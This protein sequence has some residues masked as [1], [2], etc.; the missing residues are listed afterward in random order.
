MKR[1]LLLIAISIIALVSC[2][3]IDKLSEEE[4]N[5]PMFTPELIL[6]INSSNSH[7]KAGLNSKFA[8]ALKRDVKSL[9]GRLE[10]DE[11]WNL[12]PLKHHSNLGDLPESYDA[13]VAH[14]EC[15]DVIGHVQDQSSCGS[16]W[17]N[18]AAGILQDRTCIQS[19]GQNKRTFS[20]NDI[21]SCCKLNSH[22]CNG[23]QEYNALIYASVNG[24][25]TGG[26]FVDKA[27]CL[28]YPF[29][30][31]DHHVDGVYGPCKGD[32]STP[33]CDKKCVPESKKVY[34][35]DL[36]K[37]KFPYKIGNNEQQI[38]KEI[39][40]NGP[41]TAA[42][43]VFEDFPVYK[44]GVYHHVTGKY[45]AGHAVRIIGWGVEDK[46]P[47]WLI[48]NS[49]NEGWGIGGSFKIKR[50]SN[51]CGIEANIVASLAKLDSGLKFLDE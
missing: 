48:Q 43:S 34:N 23:G 47:F 16:C 17:A 10:N 7:F 31:C 20:V 35:D 13:R 44:S 5:E 9:L 24:V 3:I 50:G 42:F 30:K 2:N 27:T 18:A 36:N 8:N 49:W 12:L 14:P 40:E 37:G 21:M 38:R 46:I 28:P 26:D 45:L 11:T 29:P 19:K 22:G 33:S 51:E 4:L 6:T 32:Y 41:V 25:P 39:F 15:K 1:N